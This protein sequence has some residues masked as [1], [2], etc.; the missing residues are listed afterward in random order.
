MIG[1]GRRVVL[2]CLLLGGCAAPVLQ[3]YSL[4]LQDIAAPVRP[5][6][7]VPVVIEVRRVTLPDEIDTQDLLTRDGRVLVR[8][9]TGR[10]AS[11]LSLQI[12]GLV[13]AALAAQHP[14]TLVTAEAQAGPVALRLFITVSR[15][16]VTPQGEA[17]LDA[18]W[19]MVSSG[20]SRRDRGSF[21]AAAPQGGAMTDGAI[22]ALTEAVVQKLAAAIILP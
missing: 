9:A 22:A 6:G 5:L 4:D 13:T 10:W 16:D 1:A 8:S 20:S 11:R 12:T 14:D 18:D 21:H 3:L 19:Q 15:L 7:A 2:L 17:V